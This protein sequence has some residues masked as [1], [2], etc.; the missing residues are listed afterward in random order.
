MKVRVRAEYE[1]ESEKQRDKI[2][3]NN[4]YWIDYNMLCR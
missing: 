1:T 4:F 3:E 2:N